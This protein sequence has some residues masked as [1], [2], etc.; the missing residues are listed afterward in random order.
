[1]PAT[2]LQALYTRINNENLTDF[3]ESNALISAPTPF[4]NAEVSNKNTTVLLTGIPP[5]KKGSIR[6]YFNRR[7]FTTR[8]GAEPVELDWGSEVRIHDLI[9]KLNAKFDLALVEDD[10]VDAGL[11][12]RDELFTSFSVT[13]SSDSYGWLGSFVLNLQVPAV[14]VNDEVTDTDLDDDD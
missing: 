5:I 11:P 10:L 6:F 9:P 7:A 13:A 3:N 14:D 12:S 4:S 8:M 2:A 1:M